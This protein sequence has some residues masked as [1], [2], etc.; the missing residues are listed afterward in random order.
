[1]RYLSTLP[2]RLTRPL[3]RLTPALAAL[4]LLAAPLPSALA[5]GPGQ[6]GGQ[7]RAITHPHACPGPR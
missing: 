6:A 3:R 2:A 7:G 5:Q 1:M 4:V